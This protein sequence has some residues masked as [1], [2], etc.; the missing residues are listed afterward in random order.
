[1]P[2]SFTKYA[3]TRDGKAVRQ[4]FSAAVADGVLYREALCI[5]EG[6]ANAFSAQAQAAG[7]QHAK[8][9]AEAMAFVP[10]AA[11][12]VTGSW[13]LE[14]SSTNGERTDALY[15]IALT[16]SGKLYLSISTIREAPGV[17]SSTSQGA[18]RLCAM[19]MAFMS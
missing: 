7:A 12:V 14:S 9:Y 6:Q 13:T 16:V 2:V 19:S 11:G 4:S 18:H 17:G 10:T 15:S 3:E 8:L 1:M 5:D